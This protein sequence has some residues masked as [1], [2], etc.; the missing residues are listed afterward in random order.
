MLLS[1]L[2]K[3]AL[4][5]SQ[6]KTVMLSHSYEWAKYSQ[7]KYQAKSKQGRLY[8]KTKLFNKNS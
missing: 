6:V 1:W 4:Q 2:P 7:M 3:H 5:L 8:S